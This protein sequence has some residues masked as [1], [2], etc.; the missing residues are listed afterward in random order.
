[1]T[2]FIKILLVSLLP[3]LAIAKEIKTTKAIIPIHSQKVSIQLP[4]TWKAA[5]QQ[6]Q[7]DSYLI[8][9]IPKNESIKNWNNIVSIQG[10]RGLSFLYS[11]EQFLNKIAA[12]FETVCG[13]NTIYNK[14]GTANIDGYS[15]YNAILGC[16]KAPKPHATGINKN[17]SEIGYYY[18][19]QGE[20]DIY[21]IHKSIR[22][23]SFNLDDSPLKK[24]NIK[25]FLK[26]IT[27][28]EL[29]KNEG[30]PTVCVK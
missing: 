28:I 10:F 30:S 9:F 1:M 2:I 6:K 25:E 17:Q 13:E 8:E 27:P 15:T 5:F 20:N 29:C 22:G 21:L 24:E 23:N 7:K 4:S 19:I 16:S 26:I 18:S 11:A 12:R 3:S 14:L